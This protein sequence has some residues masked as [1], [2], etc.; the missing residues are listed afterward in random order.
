MSG[1]PSSA[2]CT[3]WQELALDGRI[4]EAIKRL[5]WQTPTPVQSGCIPLALKGRDLAIQSRTGSGKTAAFLIP[6]LQRIITETEQMRSRRAERNPVALILLPSVELCEQTVEV[7]NALAK[8][9]RPRVVVDNLTS[10][11]PITKARLAS[12]PIL[13]ATAA[14]LG[15]QCRSGAVTA[16]ELKSLRC[17][18]IDEADLLLS[19]AE[20]SLR[21]VQS[22]LPPSTQTILSSATLTDGVA[23]IKGQLLQNPV[24]IRLNSG[25]EEEEEEDD[26]GT[27][28]GDDGAAPDGDKLLVETRMT[29]RGGTPNEKLRHYYLVATDECHHHTLLYALYRLGH[30]KGKTLIFVNSEESTYK[31][32]SFLAQ[33]SVEALVYDSNLPL[34]VRVDALHRFQVGSVAT[35]VCTDGTL[36]GVDRLKESIAEAGAQTADSASNKRKEATSAGL[37]ALQRG[38]DFSDVSNVILFDG[39]ASP[40][41]S[42][43]ARYTHRVGRAG[44]AGK[45]GMAITFFSVQQAQ[46]VTRHLRQY[47]S[48]TH[49]SFEP[50]KQLQRRE[51]AKLQYRVDNVLASITR[52]STRRQRVAAV[53]AELTRSAYLTNHMSDKDGAV[54]QRILSR[55]KKTTKCDSALLDVPHYMR[56]QSADTPERYRKRVSAKA[57][58]SR[59]PSRRP[60]KRSRDPLSSVASAVKKG[61]LKRRKH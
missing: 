11:G 23:H 41:T 30:I 31:L 10:R 18:V 14:L 17:V 52:S 4:L 15:K 55:A 35:L 25:E 39:V 29:V 27:G 33:V 58:S 12:A 60:S 37:G 1:P 32:H 24:T 48:G 40:T 54:L 9:M 38:I 57:A 61:A 8:Y 5:R 3:T 21:A 7:A 56:I 49:D 36:E 16:D 13:V 42:A 47:L 19:I 2:I 22:V 53:A 43:F 26:D 45:G 50:F 46:K 20:N 44:R 28:A 6:I 34:N 51:A 59:R